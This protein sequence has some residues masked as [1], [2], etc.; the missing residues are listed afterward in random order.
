MSPALINHLAIAALHYHH[1]HFLCVILNCWTSAATFAKAYLVKTV[2]AEAACEV[3]RFL[4][5][6]VVAS[7]GPSA[8]A[9][10]IY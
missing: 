5:A 8:A 6:S 3:R 1:Y 10:L 4:H 9:I 2:L 7:A